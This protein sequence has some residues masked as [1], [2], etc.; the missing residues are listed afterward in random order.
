MFAVKIIK[1]EELPVGTPSLFLATRDS[2]QTTP[3]DIYKK[4]Y[5]YL[6]ATTQQTMLFS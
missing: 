5:H 2:H 1:K 3:N 6:V 4:D